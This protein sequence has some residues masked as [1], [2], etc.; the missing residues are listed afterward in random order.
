MVEN[1][2]RHGRV[3]KNGTGSEVYKELGD[4]A[5]KSVKAVAKKEQEEIKYLK[6]TERA[7]ERDVRPM[8]SR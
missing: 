2:T 7:N 5:L 6:Q 4:A 1:K 8:V 3:E